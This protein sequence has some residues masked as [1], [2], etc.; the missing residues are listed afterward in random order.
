MRKGNNKKG[1]SN[2]TSSSY[3]SA[4]GRAVNE[5]EYYDQLYNTYANKSCGMIDPE[6]IERLCSDLQVAHTDVRI[7]MLAWKMQA[8]KQG[9]FTLEEWRRGLKRL[10]AD[11]IAK[12]KK[13]LPELQQEVRRSTNILD[14]YTYAFK[15]CLTGMKKS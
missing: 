7:L 8:E 1:Y 12:L 2:P 15:Y 13:A 5:W 4:S 6:G 14:F 9:Y 3:S 10:R 11:T